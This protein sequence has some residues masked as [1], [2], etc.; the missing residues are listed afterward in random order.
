M[1]TNI[2][3]EQNINA[4]NSL[5]DNCNNIVLV[6]HISPDGDAMGS[7]LSMCGL[8]NNLGKNATDRKS[9]V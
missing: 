2:I 7:S 1:I 9:V 5:I 8:L 4:A 3:S 6:A